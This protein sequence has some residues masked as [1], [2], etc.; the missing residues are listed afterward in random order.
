MDK[1]SAEKPKK[2]KPP[3]AVDALA[4][5]LDLSDQYF[6][7]TEG[8]RSIDTI[9]E[10][11][12]HNTELD[13]SRLLRMAL[14]RKFVSEGENLCLRKVLAHYVTVA[15]SDRKVPGAEIRVVDDLRAEYKRA[16]RPIFA[17]RY[18]GMENWVEASQIFDLML[19]G[20]VLHADYDKWRTSHEL[21]QTQLM[22]QVMHMVNDFEK[23]L[24][25]VRALVTGE[26]EPI[27]DL[28]EKH[29]GPVGE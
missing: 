21:G 15:R 11:Y 24:V 22:V 28:L 26:Q 27:S 18:E 4:M 10:G 23:L 9:S 19:N 5:F 1:T 8:L 13:A 20:N 2:D 25:R 6:R 7:H 16:K 12:E 17:M 14:L 29:F 3:T